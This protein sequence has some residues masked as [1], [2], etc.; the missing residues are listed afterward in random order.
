MLFARKNREGVFAGKV[1]AIIGTSSL[2]IFW[3][4]FLQ[5]NGA[6]VVVLVSS[7]Q[8]EKYRKIG[9]FSFKNTTFQSKYFS[10]NFA[11]FINRKVDYCFLASRPS[12]A[13]K[14]L[15]LLNSACLKEACVINFSSF[16]NYGELENMKYVNELRGYFEGFFTEDKNEVQLLNRNFKISLCGKETEGYELKR[17][18]S[19]AGVDIIK[20][21][22]NKGVFEQR[23]AVFAL[24]NLILQVYDRSVASLLDD[25]KMREQIDLAIK[26][27]CGL[28]IGV[29]ASSILPNIYIVSDNYK[30]EFTS[31]KDFMLLCS[32]FDGVD[33]FETPVLYNWLLEAAKK[34]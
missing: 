17:L 15:L 22:N 14:D 19:Q 27:Y 16:Y 6:E 10:F 31:K 34:Y 23:L 32:L 7:D 5:D 25:S 21:T 1:V 24:M 9:S 26:E 11:S 2:A 29:D 30:G 12:E 18:L 20:V 33:Y 13:K 8:V 4:A 28:R 3:A